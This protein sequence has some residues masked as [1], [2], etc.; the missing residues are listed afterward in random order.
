MDQPGERDL[1]GGNLVPILATRGLHIAK[2]AYVQNVTK[3]DV[4]YFKIES[5]NIYV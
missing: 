4:Y 5:V 1:H 3:L 2:H